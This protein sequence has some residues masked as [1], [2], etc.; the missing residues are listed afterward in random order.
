[1]SIFALVIL[2]G[3]IDLVFACICAKAAAA[4]EGNVLVE[5]LL[6]EGGH[7]LQLSWSGWSAVFGVNAD[8]GT[9]DLD[10]TKE[11]N[12]QRAARR[13][14][15]RLFGAMAGAVSD[16]VCKADEE[17]RPLREVFTVNV[18]IMKPLAVCREAKVAAQAQWMPAPGAASRV[19]RPCLLRCGVLVR[20][21]PA[22]GE[23]MLPGFSRQ[24]EQMCSERRP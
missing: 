23:W 4:A 10:F 19:R 17:L 6:P 7:G 15:Y 8:G 13:C 20:R 11:G 2:R 18:M 12:A 1:M 21:R 5:V 16:L 3:S 24:S 14:P 9:P 22:G